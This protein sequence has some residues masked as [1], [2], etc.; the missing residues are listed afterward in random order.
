MNEA[1]NGLKTPVTQL[2]SV[3]KV[4]AEALMRLGAETIGDLI[5]L[6]PRAYENR[7]DI[8]LLSE[9]VNGEKSALCLTVATQP[10]KAL[11]R[12]GMSLLKFRAYDESGTAEIIYFNQDFLAD[13]FALGET[14]RFYG[15]VERK[16]MPSGKD[17]FSLSSPVAE[18]IRESISEL[19]PLVPIYPLSPP[20]NQ[21]LMGKLI[22]ESL[23]YLRGDA[24]SDFLDDDIKMRNGLAGR[25]FALRTIHAPLSMREL[26]AA[27]KR[28][29]F[30]EF[31]LFSLGTA[32]AGR[33][34][35]PTGGAVICAENDISDLASALP[36]DLTGAQKRVIEE[37]KTDL[38][39]DT[40]MSRL[41]CGDVGCGKTVVAAAA[42]LIAVRSGKQAALMAPTEILATQ[43]YGDLEKIFSSLGI[44]TALLCGS[45]PRAEK[46]RIYEALAEC[47]PEKR[48]DIV[49][50]THALISDGVKFSSLG[51]VVNDEQ[52]KFGV[53]QRSALGEKGE[54]VHMLVMSATPI[55]RS[56][57]LTLYGDL[58]L[59]VID[60]M[61]PGRQRVDTFAVDEGYRERLI[62]FIRK[63]T[64]EGGQV[65]VVCPAV[66]EREAEDVEDAVEGDIFMSEISTGE[67][68][69]LCFEEKNSQPELKSAVKYAE[70]LAERLPDKKIAFVHGKMKPA[71][72]DSV[73][74]SFAAG[75][76]DVLV[77]TTVIEVGVN[78][79][80]ACL[81]IVE[82]AERFGLSQL[83]QLRGRVGRG[84]RK[85]YC[86]LVSDS[87]SE[88]ARERLETMRK[89]YDGFTIAEKDLSMRGPGD[90]VGKNGGAV[91]QSGAL[92]FRLADMLLDGELFSLAMS[93]AKMLL[94][95][96]PTLEAH[97][98]LLH[99]INELF[100]IDAN[101]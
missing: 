12:R 2:K 25:A 53:R 31:F 72:K 89:T 22:S 27:K 45:T 1:K 18:P 57:A 13:K 92:R 79:P 51:L 88:R 48:I 81:M 39:S 47:D 96:D 55:P 21:N 24:A 11:I 90:F 74:Q 78:V 99:E 34:Q 50:G 9:T 59:S 91:R 95:S 67:A 68:F 8:K 94:D 98:A 4:R 66:E 97:G 38:A 32:F 26:E 15:K 84:S 52:H 73:M 5:G 41:V 56:L 62:A 46:R 60:E 100:D 42:M 3:G 44:K 54:N 93:E 10:K 17:V 87:K 28:L 40:P 30:E 86:V 20:L 83:H 101:H 80:N 58:D 85:S 33:R 63:L 61:P 49:I 69:S 70:E 76:I 35:R 36:Y 14:F 23:T 82:N 75:E 64:G 19:A 7:G 77:S 37:I 65:Y 29:I 71:E 6:Y 43:H 16:K